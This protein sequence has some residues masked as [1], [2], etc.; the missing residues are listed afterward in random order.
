VLAGYDRD[1]VRKRYGESLADELTQKRAFLS[2]FH[3]GS[4]D[5]IRNHVPE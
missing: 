4:P 2:G 3:P 1:A 5:P